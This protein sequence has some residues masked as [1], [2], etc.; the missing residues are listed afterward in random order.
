M[1]KKVFFFLFVMSGLFLFSSCINSFDSGYGS[2]SFS[3]KFGSAADDVVRTVSSNEAAGDD[4][5]LSVECRL[6]QDMNVV[7]DVSKS[8]LLKD[9]W[10]TSFS[11]K[12]IPYRNNYFVS[13]EI[14]FNNSLIYDARSSLIALNERNEN[15]SVELELVQHNSSVHYVLGEHGK[16]ETGVNVP[17]E[18]FINSDIILP[19][20]VKDMAKFDGWYLSDKFVPD[21]KIT[22]L[23]KS[24]FIGDVTLYAKWTEL[25]KVSCVSIIPDNTGE[26]DF[27]DTV[28]LECDTADAAIYYTLDGAVPSVHSLKYD[29]KSP[30]CLKDSWKDDDTV[31]IKAFAVK[32]GMAASG[33]TEKTYTMKRYTVSFDM[34]DPKAPPLKDITGLKKG[35]KLTADQ[36]VPL[37]RADYEFLGWKFNG[38]YVTEGHIVTGDMVLIP[39][40][41]EF[42]KVGDVTFSIGSGNIDAGTVVTL[43]TEP[44]DATIYYTDDGITE[45][46]TGS[47]V[48]DGN[49][50]TINNDIVIKAF[51]VKDG[52]KD[53]DVTTVEYNVILYKISFSGGGKKNVVI[54]PID[55]KK[56]EKIPDDKLTLQADEGYVLSGWKDS[57]GNT[58][59][60]SYTVKESTTITAQWTPIDYTITYNT[61]ITGVENPAGNPGTYTI[62]SENIMLELPYKKG[63]TM[64][65]KSDNSE[66]STI[67]KGTTGNIVLN[68]EETPITYRVVYNLNGAEGT[69][70]AAIES[71]RYDSGFV[72]ES[73]TGYTKSGFQ[74]LGLWNTKPDGTG[75][76]YSGSVNNLTDKEGETVNLY[77][78]WKDIAPGDITNLTC[79]MSNGKISLS[80]DNPDDGDLA[81]IKFTFSPEPS[82]GAVFEETCNDS[83]IHMSKD[84]TGLTNGT[85]YTIT[86]NAVDKGGNES[87]GITKDYSLY[88]LTTVPEKLTGYISTYAPADDKNWTYVEFGD[89][90]QSLKKN[91]VKLSNE[92]TTINTWKCFYGDDG[93]YYVENNIKW[94]RQPDETFLDGTSVNGADVYYFKLE[95]LKWRILDKNYNYSSDSKTGTL[96]LSEIPLSLCRFQFKDSCNNDRS[97]DGHIVKLNNYEHSKIR[98]FLNGTAYTEKRGDSGT[99]GTLETKNDFVDKGFINKAFDLEL[100]NKYL[101]DVNVNNSSA[102][103]FPHGDTAASENIYACGNTVDKAFLLSVDDVTNPDYGFKQNKADNDNARQRGITDYIISEYPVRDANNGKGMSLRSPDN[104]SE[105]KRAYCNSTGVINNTF[106]TYEFNVVP[107]IVLPQGTVISGM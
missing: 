59:D 96:M 28:V 81:K 51:A 97:I 17:S 85:V 55:L 37:E 65:W 12:N 78:K 41:R 20:P 10:D 9:L 5:K 75:T 46:T 6:M 1:A 53:S 104:N 23:G 82:F 13:I 92:S 79:K 50:I 60:S 107:A 88:A 100:M 98:A 101:A 40:W 69:A 80:W 31:T 44:S 18:Y 70:P 7:R 30:V 49:P 26:A 87:V 84:I 8:V 15:A 3:F 21:E 106:T 56:G 90:P 54:D 27:D 39:G 22:S 57:K 58:V 11:F 33:I 68:L 45:P 62:E 66:I 103:A 38:A 72:L 89:W 34:Q 64:K 91:D 63:Y 52:M 24:C 16:F 74:S 73:C 86:I 35:D 95:P 25:D 42:G 4:T 102:T 48:Y 94:A 77:A 32:E 99:E 105:E 36:L 14:F 29:N 71:C 43:G 83:A 76:D 67:T 47:K 61:G 19:V 93:Y 2:N